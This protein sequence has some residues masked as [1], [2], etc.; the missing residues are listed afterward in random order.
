MISTLLASDVL[1]TREMLQSIHDLS[2]PPPSR[3]N[4]EEIKVDMTSVEESLNKHKK[5]DRWTKMIKKLI[6]EN[7]DNI[8]KNNKQAIDLIQEFHPKVYNRLKNNN[9]IEKFLFVFRQ[10]VSNYKVVKNDNINRDELLKEA[11][12]LRRQASKIIELL[13]K[14]N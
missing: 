2:C 11:I 10:V 13:Y 12:M 8:P 1:D 5:L 6:R 9:D 14:V 4:E 7:P 3:E